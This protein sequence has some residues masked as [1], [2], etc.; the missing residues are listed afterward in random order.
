MQRHIGPGNGYTLGTTTLLKA[1]VMAKA[2]LK[3][4]MFVYIFLL[5]RFVASTRATPY[6]SLPSPAGETWE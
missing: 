5:V 2:W 1:W 3:V 6:A 4:K